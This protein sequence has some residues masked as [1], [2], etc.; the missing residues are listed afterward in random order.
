MCMATCVISCACL[1]TGVFCA[2]VWEPVSGTWSMC[3]HALGNVLCYG[4][5]RRSVFTSF[6]Q[7]FHQALC[8]CKHYW[9]EWFSRSDLNLTSWW[10]HTANAVLHFTPLRSCAPLTQSCYLAWWRNVFWFGDTTGSCWWLLCVG[11]FSDW[12]IKELFKN[13]KRSSVTLTTLLEYIWFKSICQKYCGKSRT[14]T[15][16]LFVFHCFTAS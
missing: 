13:I 14:F 5:Q 9:Y 1:C 4:P 6:Q 12:W 8:V 3:P 15:W 2:P 10:W 16:E 11:C 7:G